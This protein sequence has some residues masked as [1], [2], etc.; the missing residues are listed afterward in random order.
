MVRKIK[1]PHTDQQTTLFDQLL[2]K[3]KRVSKD[4]FATNFGGI[5]ED[6]VEMLTSAQIQQAVEEARDIMESNPTKLLQMEFGL[7]STAQELEKGAVAAI[8][9]TFTL[10]MQ[11]YSAG[12]AICVGIGSLSHSRPMQESLHYW[13]SKVFLSD[14]VGMSDL[15]ERE[16]RGLFSR[17]SDAYLRYYEIS[18]GVEI[19]EPCLL[20]DGPPHR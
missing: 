18:H 16:N 4:A 17:Y 14:A 20:L 1:E 8:D 15:I 13:S 9:G 2:N 6:V 12:Q 10:P 7:F 5:P 3:S 19:D 11:K